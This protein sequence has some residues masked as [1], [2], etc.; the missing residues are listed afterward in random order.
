MS[1]ISSLGSSLFV[2]II[3]VLLFFI[4]LPLKKKH[5]LCTWNP[6]VP[7]FDWSL[8]LVLEAIFRQ[9]FQHHPSTGSH[10]PT[11][12]QPT[13]STRRD[14]GSALLSQGHWGQLGHTS[15]W[16]TMEENSHRTSWWFHLIQKRF[17]CTFCDIGVGTNQVATISKLI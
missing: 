16:K 6:N 15:P 14:V 11:S 10:L 5:L 2:K 9:N 17:Q 12:T 4:S 13:W 7:C 3:F 8:D 1:P